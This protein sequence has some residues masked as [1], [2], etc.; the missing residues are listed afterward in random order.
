M[1]QLKE[2]I[3]RQQFEQPLEA[4][5]QEVQI[6]KVIPKKALMDRKKYKRL[7]DKLREK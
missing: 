6:M 4:A 5:G 2:D 3:L 7:T 1:R